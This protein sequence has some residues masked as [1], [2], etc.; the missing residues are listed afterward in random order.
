MLMLLICEAFGDIRLK[1]PTGRAIGAVALVAVFGY[2][3]HANGNELW[4]SA[5]SWAGRGAQVRSELA[6]IDLAGPH[7]GL[8]F[9][10]EDPA[11]QP[12]VPSTH[13]GMTAF[14]YLRTKDS[15][16]S[17]AFTA[18]ELASAPAPDRRV[19]DIVLA[20][21]FGLQL[22]PI[23][24]VKPSAKAPPP[25]IVA[26]QGRS[27]DSAPGC[28]TVTPSGE[29]AASQIAL[30]IGGVQLSTSGGDPV[31]LALGR[32]SPGYAYPLQPPLQPHRPALLF[33]PRDVAQTPWRLLIRPTKQSVTACGLNLAGFG[34]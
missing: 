6:A 11:G 27:A 4:N 22:R 25:H 28:I 20:R 31:D 8:N 2:A 19:A 33:V 24:S 29:P 10:P 34:E 13:T 30:P 7:V 18:S 12:P 17:P 9:I 3:V 1:A 26:T 15:Y 21:A 32:F 23:P 5:H 14:Q 16:G